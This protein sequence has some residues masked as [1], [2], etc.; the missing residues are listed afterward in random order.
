MSN[1]IWNTLA[2]IP[3]PFECSRTHTAQH[4]ETIQRYL[5][6]SLQMDQWFLAVWFGAVF[7]L[8]VLVTQIWRGGRRRAATARPRANGQPAAPRSPI[9]SIGRGRRPAPAAAVADATA[10][11]N[12]GRGPGLS[13]SSSALPAC[14]S[15]ARSR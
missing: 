11:W 5:Q 10:K 13:P 14:C 6:H 7:M 4:C 2:G 9:R 8:A 12:G 15:T 3:E 1:R